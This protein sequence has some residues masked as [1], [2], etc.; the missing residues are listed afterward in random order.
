MKGNLLSTEELIES[1][2]KGNIHLERM[3]QQLS[4]AWAPDDAENLRAL[5]NNYARNIICSYVSRF[6]MISKGML[7]AIETKN[8]SSYALTGRSLIE[9][10]ATLRYYVLKKYKPLFDKS[11]L[12]HDEMRSLI[13]IDDRHL[14]GSRF[15]W[16]SFLSGK[17]LTIV[18]EQVRVLRNKKA[19]V[20]EIS[21]R[22][23]EDQVNVTTCIESWAEAQP[24]I[25]L[26]YSLFCDLVHPNVGS[27]FLIASLSNGKLSFIPDKG[28]SFGAKIFEQ[29]FPILV[30]LIKEFGECL[31]ML[32][33]TIWQ[34]D[35]I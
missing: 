23:S 12:S 28:E 30:S 33:R 31:A 25:L 20:T 8:F 7:T 10:T 9:I 15:D 11:N 17:Y 22:L 29:S 4:I 18:E 32:M 2:R 13:E 34:D 27:S 26:G 3:A 24:G 6:S 35:E 16:T 1:F 21:K 5:H 19:K 14:R